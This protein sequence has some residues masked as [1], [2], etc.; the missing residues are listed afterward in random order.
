MKK[1]LISV[2]RYSLW[3]IIFI[4]FNNYLEAQIIT[5]I[6]GKGS[7][8]Y[9][10]DGGPATSA[11]FNF[12]RALT[13]G[14]AGNMYISDL[15]TSVIR[16]IDTFGIIS[17]YGGNGTAGYSVDGIPATNAELKEPGGLAL[18]DTGNLYISDYGN[19]RIRKIDTARII[20]TVA[21]IGLPGYSG[22]GIPATTAKIWSPEDVAI[23]NKYGNV[24]IAD[25]NNHRVRK[26]TAGIISTVA[27]TGVSGYT[28]DGLSATAAELYFKRHSLVHFPCRRIGTLG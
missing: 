23:D 8:G 17:T 20:N 14:K 21:G 22:D 16:K 26:V 5:T 27:G 25:F 3:I 28:G 24:Y 10:G 19:F 7:A 1:K 13:L 9:S 15:Y 4:C 6:A 12:P 18:D 11:Q 2:F